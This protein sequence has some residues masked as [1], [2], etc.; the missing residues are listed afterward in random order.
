MSPRGNPLIKALRVIA[1]RSHV[2]P[3]S[4]HKNLVIDPEMDAL[5]Q[6]MR[7]DPDLHMNQSDAMRHLMVEGAKRVLASLQ[8]AE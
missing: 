4:E 5:L 7:S 1:E 6:V 2:P 8:Q 3:M